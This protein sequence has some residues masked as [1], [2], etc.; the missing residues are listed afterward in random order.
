VAAGR[1]KAEAQAAAVTEKAD[2][3]ALR[4]QVVDGRLAVTVAD[5]GLGPG[6]AATAGT[7]V[8]LASIRD[9][10]AMLYGTEATLTLAERSDGGAVATVTVPYRVR[11]TGDA[12]A[13]PR[14]G[15]PA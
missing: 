5:T 3:E 15:S 14:T 10:L 2:A 13:P 1:F 12:A 11:T 6:R 9:R 7:G 8:G 4:R